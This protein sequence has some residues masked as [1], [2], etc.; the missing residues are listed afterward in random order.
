MPEQ[1]VKFLL[2]ATDKTQQAFA[3]AKRSIGDLNNAATGLGRALSLAIP[4]LSVAG[5]SS[6]VK[7]SIDAADSLN[8]MSK[9]TGVAVETLAGFKLAAAQ[10]GVELETVAK[11]VQK[12][13]SVVFDAGNGSKEAAD[14]LQRLGLSLSAL[15]QQ[16]PEQQFFSLAGALKNI[17]QD[18][19]PAV[20]ID[21]L[22]QKMAKLAPLLDEGADGLRKMVD[23]GKRLNPITQEMAAQADRFNDELA[24]LKAASGT[25]AI[26]IAKDLLP[27]LTDTAIAMN[28]L[29]QEGHPV[30][31]LLR[32]IAGIGKI[33]L[34]LAI[35]PPDFS[36]KERLK[37]LR[38]EV[39]KLQHQI[40]LTRGAGGGLI[41]RFL[42]GTESELKQKLEVAKNQI[43][44]FEKFADKIRPK[45]DTPAIPKE[46]VKRIGGEIAKIGKP[47][48]PIDV[49]DN[50]SFITRN[51]EAAD[52]IKQQYRDIN[53]LQGLIAKDGETLDLFGGSFSASKYSGDF[54]TQQFKDVNELQGE[55]A[56][57]TADL[58]QKYEE[59]ADPL[60]PY[61]KQLEELAELKKQFPQLADT[62]GIAEKKVLD[63]LSAATQKNNDIAR[64][65]G[66][67]FSSAFEDSVV[68]GKKLSDVF[69]NLAKDIFKLA[70]REYLTKPILEATKAL[71]D[72]NSASSSSSSGT[73]GIGSIIGAILGGFGGGSTSS[74]S[75][76]SAGFFDIFAQGGVVGGAKGLNKYSGSV[77]S[78]PT[79]FPFA[80]GIGLMG[81]A[82]AEAILPLKR[83]SDGKLGVAG[84]SGGA[85]VNI[86][87]NVENSGGDGGEDNKENGRELGRQ[88][89]STVRGILLTEKRPGGLLA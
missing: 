8:D 54:I 21:L 41:N 51:K 83:G 49:F 81:E 74:F 40:D 1:N 63:D 29:T 73:G 38:E 25:T 33:P 6:F 86:V 34:D 37:E 23:E 26:A 57:H 13:S 61:R 19:R 84:G 5:F 44:S 89:A 27:S 82:G 66:L 58:K 36:V 55:I 76:S 52:F 7:A 17:A 15:K 56:K 11:G 88:I 12:F 46:E 10:S 50:A 53:E 64:D 4:A 85:T 24:K 39:G 65:L 59:L 28:K 2:T 18:Q 78:S 62:W 20:L 75:S 31:A 14:K 30:L 67:T 9:S 42:F 69:A 43:A 32:G 22:G 80:S 47:D 45:S 72:F 3:S 35:T 16:S 71:L 60:I 87:V 70:I 48:K 68:G 79:I 77:V